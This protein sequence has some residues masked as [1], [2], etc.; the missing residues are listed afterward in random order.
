MA[1]ASANIVNNELVVK[2]NSNADKVKIFVRKHLNIIVPLFLLMVLTSIP[3]YFKS[4]YSIEDIFNYFFNTNAQAMWVGSIVG[5]IMYIMTVLLVLNIIGRAY[6]KVLDEKWKEYH[7]ECLPIKEKMRSIL[8]IH[9]IAFLNLENSVKTKSTSIKAE[10]DSLAILLKG[11]LGSLA[12]SVFPL[13]LTSTLLF[14]A[15]RSEDIITNVIIAEFVIFAFIHCIMIFL[16]ETNKRISRVNAI[17]DDMNDSMK[18][19]K[20]KIQT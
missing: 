15:D 16:A 20:E 2:T 9:S 6:S 1:E 8:N 3:I 13:F 17:I 11:L 18:F 4:D 5:L 7:K 14:Q 10:Y 12:A 19:T